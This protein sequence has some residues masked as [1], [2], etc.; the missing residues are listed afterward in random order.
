MASIDI[1]TTTLPHRCLYHHGSW[2]TLC[3]ATALHR[4]MVVKMSNSSMRVPLCCKCQLELMIT[5]TMMKRSDEYTKTLSCFINIKAY[6]LLHILVAV[7]KRETED[8]LS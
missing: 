1:C 5:S 3:S 6:S 7:E 2:Y 4:T 8:E